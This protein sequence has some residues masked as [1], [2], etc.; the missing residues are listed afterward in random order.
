MKKTIRNRAATLCVMALM[1]S[2]TSVWAAASYSA[3]DTAIVYGDYSTAVGEGAW[4]GVYDV[5]GFPMDPLG[6]TS[7][8]TAYGAFARAGV[9][10]P[11]PYEQPYWSIGNT[12]IGVNSVAGGNDINGATAIGDTAKA[13]GT[14]STAVGRFSLANAT[15]ST[16]IGSN[17]AATGENSTA[18]GH[19]S[20]ANATD[21][22]AIG[23]ASKATGVSSTAVGQRAEATM[24]NSTALGQLARASG[25]DSTALGQ[26]ADA[27]A[28][29]ATAIGKAA[30][31]SGTSSTAVG[32]S[33]EATGSDSTALGSFAEA[34]S[35]SSTA[36]GNYSQATGL[37]GTA[38]GKSAQAKGSNSTA[39][40]VSAYAKGDYSTALG[41]SAYAEGA[42]STALGLSATTYGLNSTALGQGARTGGEYVLVDPDNEESDLKL[43][44]VATNATAV[45]QNAYAA[46]DYSTAIGQS[47][48]ATGLKSTALG[49]NAQA[50]HDNSVALGANSITDRPNSVSVGSPGAERQITNVADGTAMTDAVN[51]RQLYRTGAL[52]AALS[53]LAPI[54]YD[55]SVKTQF[56]FGFGGYHNQQALA[57]G[58][59]HY[60]ND[61]VLMNFGAAFSGGENMFKGGITWKLGKSSAKKYDANTSQELAALKN[62]LQQQDA[63]MKKMKE[64][65]AALMKKN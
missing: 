28:A 7:Y 26:D 9:V 29:S 17:S 50:I 48:Q 64:Q 44:N 24:Q 59:N 15:N 5:Y 39:L 35:G 33:A 32:R 4:A 54:P 63:E 57:V 47:A 25:T 19:G 40:G 43:V 58:M 31:A 62:Q 61:S 41:V 2:T 6:T 12:A 37:A 1:A 65:L 42:N 30:N 34:T 14:D 21:S 38:V 55:P 8:N 11:D 13:I 53:G 45:G 51:I 60:F 23:E 56:S 10:T 18:V 16:A 20:Q 36:L 46:K 3:P 49:Q 22:T 27:T 52:S